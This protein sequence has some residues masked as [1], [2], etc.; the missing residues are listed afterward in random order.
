MKCSLVQMN[1]I[2]DKAKNI[3]MAKELIE[4]AVN[5][6]KPD[7]VLL[8]ETF[9]W[10]GGTTE[11]RL[12][13]AE[14]VPGGPAYTMC[15]DLA[16]KHRIFVHA[17]SI[18]E[19][20]AGENKVYNTTVVFNREGKQI[21]LYRKI[22]LFDVQL[23]DGSAY[24]ESATVAAGDTPV[25][26]ETPFGK[27]GLAVCNDVRLPEPFRVLSSRGMDFLVLGAAFTLH[28]GRDHWLA[29]LRARAIENQCYVIAPAQWGRHNDKRVT[30]GRSVIIDPWGVELAMAPDRDGVIVAE[31]DLQAQKKIRA[32]LPALTHRRL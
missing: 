20:V 3:A 4:K 21:A 25:V 10:A 29:L 6:E 31:I 17:G 28:T 9:D 24:K 32:E 16:E 8:P 7:W 15:Q 13:A 14:I 30:F 2:S 12:A 19:K 5:E 23:A 18:N 1:S 11:Q 22:H 27:M 26:V